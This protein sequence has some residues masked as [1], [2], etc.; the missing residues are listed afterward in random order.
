MTQECITIPFQLGSKSPNDF[1]NLAPLI[2]YSG[3]EGGGGAKLL[4]CSDP[5]MKPP[6][7][8]VVAPLQ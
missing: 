4:K 3:A 5:T 6:K 2:P 1:F 7:N 8:P